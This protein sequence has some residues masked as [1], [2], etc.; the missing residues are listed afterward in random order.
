MFIKVI[1]TELPGVRIIKPRVFRDARGF[2]LETY[3]AKRYAEAGVR[4]TFV[5]DNHSFS[6]KGILRGLHY[7]VRHAQGKLIQVVSGEIYDVAVDIRRGSPTFGKWVGVT[8]SERNKQQIYIPPGFAHGFYVVSETA[9]VMY[10]CTDFYNAG[11]EHGIL[12]SDPNLNI[13]WP[14]EGEPIISEKDDK[15]P[16]LQNAPAEHLPVFTNRV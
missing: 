4:E 13:D 9:N 11:D 16:T 12:W 10:K 8:L 2:F 5:Q 1:E 7:Q 15:H 6:T 14:L 3:H